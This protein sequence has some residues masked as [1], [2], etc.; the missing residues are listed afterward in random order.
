M[1]FLP[2]IERELRVRSRL[3][4]SY[5]LRMLVAGA[6]MLVI[7][8]TTVDRYMR[9]DEQSMVMLMGS[10]AIAMI[11]ATIRLFFYRGFDQRGKAGRDAG[12]A[13]S[14]AVEEPRHHSGQTG[15]GGD[16]R[17]LR[18][19]GF[20]AGLLYS[21]VERRRN[22]GVGCA[23]V[24]GVDRL[25]V[26]VA[27][28]GAV[29]F[30]D[31]QGSE[32]DR[33]GDVGRN[34]APECGSADIRVFGGGGVQ[35]VSFSIWSSTSRGLG[36]ADVCCRRSCQ[37]VWRFPFLGGCRGAELVGVRGV[38]GCCVLPGEA[39]ETRRLRVCGAEEGKETR[40]DP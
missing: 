11:D 34:A 32:I 33:R 25:A 36:H 5:L 1:N 40:G 26:H 4:S 29:V 35:E 19:A 31:W 15:V 10:A 39:G 37:S 12:A 9:R 22:G 2:V 13:V 21:D 27:V 30:D 38:A 7:L 18:Y 6:G 16:S 20:G 8:L 23:C 3:W 24:R 28:G 17:L 14:D